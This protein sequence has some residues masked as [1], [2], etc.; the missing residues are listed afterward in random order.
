ME[1]SERLHRPEPERTGPVRHAGTYLRDAP[2]GDSAQDTTDA[3]AAP[4]AP[5]AAEGAVAHGV[6]LGYKV[7]EEQILHG[8]LLAQRLG[9]AT[10]KLGATG[11]GE[12]NVLIERFLHL[13]KDMGTL[14]VDALES[15]ARSPAIR[16][17]LARAAQ[18]A[19][20]PHA[21]QDR[22]DSA[23][24]PEPAAG[25]GFSIEVASPRRTQV[26]LDLR[27]R[28]GRFAPRVHALHAAD[29]SVPPL[30]GVSFDMDAARPE[31]MLRIE[32]PD[33]QP[34]AMYTGVVVDSANNEPRGFLSVQLL[35]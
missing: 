6:R 17:G 9:K 35:P 29:P 25:S 13:Y 28:P 21:A 20:A 7:V 31:P 16:S 2:P 1:A 11:A 19:Q 3:P 10:S 24:G 33:D 30:T 27:L 22:A 34:A 8:R 4:N 18:A 5:N 32:V 15:L 12:V 26:T 23:A 14:C